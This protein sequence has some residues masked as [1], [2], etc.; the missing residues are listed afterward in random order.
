M[1]ADADRSC[2]PESTL[3]SLLARETGAASLDLDT[4]AWEPGRI[5]VPRDAAVA[6]QELA[7]FCNGH[8]DWIIEGCYASLIRQSLGWR[9]TLV[10]LDPGVE[11]CL[12][13]CRARPWEP[14]KYASKAEQ[15]ARLDSLLQWVREYPE[16]T[17]ELGRG[18]HLAC[19]DAYD[20]P[21][22]RLDE[23]DRV[24]TLTA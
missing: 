17:G 20:G 13:H 23:I 15:D 2:R 19:F 10:F 18:E 12:A 14:H 5:A 6:A 3:A 7:A 21:K 1:L 24:A 22:V 8:D 9:P 4:V 16:R 11:R